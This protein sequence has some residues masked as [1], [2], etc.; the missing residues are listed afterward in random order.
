[1]TVASREQLQLLESR[2]VSTLMIAT[3]LIA[4]AAFAGVLF[5]NKNTL[6]LADPLIRWIRPAASSTEIER[7]HILAR[8]FGHCLIPAAAFAVLVIG[9][10]RT[11][12]A[13]A[14]ILCVLFA[15]IDEFL[16]TF[17]PGRNGSL[18][19][20]ILPRWPG[21]F[22]QLDSDAPSSDGHSAESY[23]GSPTYC[24]STE[25]YSLMALQ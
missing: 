22:L 12:P 3:F 23:S 14:L 18:A 25:S 15:A 7:I 24:L 21:H 19:D 6:A 13:L 10:L 9:P 20:V 17:T 8:K 11:R 4:L 16:Q 5:A 2:I 1:L